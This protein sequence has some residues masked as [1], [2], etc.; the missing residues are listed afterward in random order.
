MV[1][2]GGG[3]EWQME[4]TQGVERVLGGK[5]KGTKKDWRGGV[6]RRVR[7]RK[8]KGERNVVSEREEKKKKG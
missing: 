6:E 5:E 1:G 7:R 8:E 4:G 2:E 3:E